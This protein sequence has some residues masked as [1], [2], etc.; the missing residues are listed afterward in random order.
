MAT[1]IDFKTFGTVASHILLADQPY[2][3]MLR[4][5][6]GV[7]KSQVV[8]QIAERL[9]WDAEKQ[10]IALDV[11]A[12]TRDN[13]VPLTMIE[14]RASQMTEGDLLGLPSIDGGSTTFNPP[15]WFKTACDRP[16]VLFLD[17]LDR[18]ITEVRQGFFEVA[19]SRKLS[20]WKL[21]P[22]TVIFAAVNGGQHGSQYQVADLDPAEADRWIV[23][24]V[25]PTVEDWLTW[26][27]DSGI[28]KVLWDFIN[29]NRAHLE[30]NGDIDPTVVY[31]S[32]RSWDRLN[33]VAT[34]RSL[35]E[36]D[37][38][39]LYALTAGFVGTEASV[40]LVDFIKNYER[41]ISVEDILDEGM[42]E[43]LEDQGITDLTALVEKMDAVNV[44]AEELSD[45]RSKNLAELFSRVPSEV[46]MKI[47]TQLT[48]GRDDEVNV[49]K[50]YSQVCSDGRPVASHLVELCGGDGDAVKS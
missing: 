47:W 39:I 27:T 7:G 42:F 33:S 16:C 11:P 28:D 4:G 31:P 1:A 20:G 6:H 10:R 8:Y 40:A 22:G 46:A 29:Q 32:R 3:I 23:F 44:F 41:Q 48:S 50:F 45:N 25:E 24:D 5:R 26:A 2:P 18:A 9:S 30:H 12:G 15:D 49:V 38:S 13:I 19:G 43:K 37:P 21:H 17:E 36:A 34:S 35:F 14:R